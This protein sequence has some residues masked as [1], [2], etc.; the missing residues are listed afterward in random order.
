MFKHQE[1]KDKKRKKLNTL[2]GPTA[3]FFKAKKNHIS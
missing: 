2:N 3:N 1:K